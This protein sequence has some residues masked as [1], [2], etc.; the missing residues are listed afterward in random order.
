V[1]QYDFGKTIQN[2]KFQETGFLNQ[3][4]PLLRTALATLKG[5]YE[6]KGHQLVDNVNKNLKKIKKRSKYRQPATAS[7][8]LYKPYIIHPLSSPHGCDIECGEDAAYLI[9]RQK[10][11]EEDDD[12]AIH[13][14]LIAS[15]NQLMKDARTRDALAAER[16]VLCFEMEA[17]GLMN[18]FPCLVIRG[19]CD[20]SDSHKNKEWQGFAAM[21]AA[22]YAKDL[23]HQI[24]PTSIEAEKPIGEVLGSIQRR[25]SDLKER[26]QD[27]KLNKA[28]DLSVARSPHFVVPFPSDPDFVNRPDIWTWIERQ[29]SGPESR[30]ALVGLGGF[31]IFWVHGSTR[32]TFEESYRSIADMLA[33][34]RRHDSDVNVLVLVRGWLQREDVSPWLMIIDNTDDIKMLFSKD[35]N[36]T[37]LS[38]L[39]KRENGK[40]LITSRSWDA[41]DKLTGNGKMILRVPT[42]E[43]AQALQLFQKKIG[44]DANEAA[45]LRLI[46]TL[47]YVPLAVNQAAAYIYRRSPRVTVESYLEEIH[48]SEK[49]KETLLDSDQGNIQRYEGVS[50]SVVV[51]WQVT[52]EQIKREQPRAAN[53]LSLMSFFQA[54]NIPEYMLHEYNSGNV[55]SEEADDKHGETSDF[56]FEDDLDVLRGYSLVTM[57]ATPGLLEMHSLVQFCTRLWISKFGS[58]DQWKTLFLQSA[59]EHFP[60][61]VFETWQQCQTLMPHVQPLLDKQPLEE[62]DRLERSKLLTNVSWYLVMLGD[63]S[64]AEVIVQEAVSTRTELLGQEHPDTLTSVANLASTYRNQGRWKEAEELEVRVMET[65]LRV[66]GEEHPNTLTSVAN[67]ASTFWNQGRWT[68]AEELFVRVMETRKRVLGEEHPSTLTSMHNLAFTWKNQE[69]WEDATQLLQDCFHRRENVLGADHPDTMSSASALSDWELELMENGHNVL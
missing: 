12:P 46:N 48:N 54:Q 27:L 22:A 39:P 60:S 34:P 41:A 15:G 50:N 16:D 45:S 24:A 43:E 65:S 56:D 44:R 35:D 6:M 21:M 30:F 5:T 1:F 13:Y 38:Y 23:L 63:Y 52:F 51:T 8:R 29:Y 57:T 40:I 67:L 20:Y 69:R 59:S 28:E 10:R 26:L 64:R 11:D 4:P 32:A 68:E 66:L 36:E 55:Y 53:L 18:H 42:M 25:L 31:G 37:Y 3:P 2:C 58:A 49:R 19:I 61:G 9:A 14:G 7:D 47:D 17:A 33:L 62:R